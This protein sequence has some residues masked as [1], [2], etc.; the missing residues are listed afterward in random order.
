[1]MF[2]HQSKNRS[3]LVAI[4]G[5]LLVLGIAYLVWS[6]VAAPEPELVACTMDAMICPDGSYVGR[7]PPT[8]EFAPC[9]GN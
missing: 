6:Q 7:V 5:L 2:E 9:A 3:F 8:C 1:M 4:V